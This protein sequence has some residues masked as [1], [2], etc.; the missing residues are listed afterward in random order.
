MAGTRPSTQRVGATSHNV[1][2]CRGEPCTRANRDAGKCPTSPAY[3]RL[4]V[5]KHNTCDGHFREHLLLFH[6]RAPR[7]LQ[8]ARSKL[9]ENL[10]R[11]T[12]PRD[13]RISLLSS[14]SGLVRG[15]YVSALR[16]HPYC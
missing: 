3:M 4:I 11:Q 16:A 10:M 8:Q 7:F 5:C 14:S 2:H 1:K 15:G 9:D 13:S 12:S 6:G